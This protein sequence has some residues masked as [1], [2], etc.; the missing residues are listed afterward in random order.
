MAKVYLAIQESFD[1]EVALKIMAPHLL[2]AD[3]QYGERFLREARIVAKLT[4]PHIVSVYDVGVHDGLHYLSMEYVPGQ[5]LK[6]KRQALTLVQNLR[7]VKQVAL[8]LDYAH[9]KGYVHRDIKPENILIHEEDGRAVLTDFGI[10][11]MTGLEENLTQTGVA[12]G[13]PSYMSPEHAL[14]KPVDH[15][16][17][18]YSLGIVMFYLLKGHVPFT[19]DSAVAVGLKHAVEPVPRLEGALIIFQ[20]VLEKIL[21]K[22]PDKRFQSGLEFAEVL[23]ELTAKI[24]PELEQLWRESISNPLAAKED[25]TVA[26]PTAVKAPQ[27]APAPIPAPTP[28][29][30]RERSEETKITQLPPVKAEQSR[31]AIGDQEFVVHADERP[32]ATSAQKAQTGTPVWAI[33]LVLIIAVAGVVLWRSGLLQQPS[34]VA[35]ETSVTTSQTTAPAETAPLP[36]PATEALTETENRQPEPQT[37]APT[38]QE[39]A[40]AEMPLTTENATTPST[41]TEATTAATETVTEAPPQTAP[42]AEKAPELSEAERAQQRVQQ[43]LQQAEQQ[44]KAGNLI[45]P[46]NDN[47]EASYR[48]V[49]SLQPDSAD[50]KEGLSAIGIALAARGLEQVKQKDLTAARKDYERALALAPRDRDVQVLKQRIEAAQREQNAQVHVDKAVAA[51]KK[52]Q[53]LSPPK[54]NAYEHYQKALSIHPSNKAALKGR[55]ELEQRVAKRIDELWQQ[56]QVTEASALYALAEEKYPDSAAIKN[57]AQKTILAPKKPTVTA[58]DE[59]EL[60]RQMETEIAEKTPEPPKP[61]VPVVQVAA[62]PISSLN[63]AQATNINLNRTLHVRFRFQHF[64]TSSTVLMARLYDGSRAVRISEVPVIVRGS[65]GEV[66]FVINRMVEGFPEGGYILDIMMADQRLASTSFV[67]AR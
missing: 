62:E 63:D 55:D 51:L 44:L 39:K 13:T 15:R 66:S 25:K 59:A 10:A 47:A 1:R 7:A 28:A 24:T 32:G 57:V 30:K 61:V 52:N 56:Q 31:A 3:S 9:K 65:E 5:D 36:A 50:A 64:T 6:H 18:L 48:E 29:A 20:P 17:D 2:N 21:A 11:R 23:E 22:Q 45:E 53:L 54:N 33:V 35:S 42:V 41:E 37:S 19:A 49:L 40:P 46:E 14:G 27:A 34:D 12:I 26:T 8:A 16:A 67:V 58:E 43:L 4:H 60:L 38:E